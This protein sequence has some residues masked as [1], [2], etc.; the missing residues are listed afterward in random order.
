MIN[1]TYDN[2]SF[3][4]SSH[5]GLA[6]FHMALSH[7][8]IFSIAICMSPSFWAGLDS[9]IGSTLTK[10]FYSLEKSTLIQVTIF[11]SVYLMIP[12]ALI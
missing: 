5:G 7:P 2:R 3:L 8:K 12:T 4:G 9:L 1:I 6:A 11:L 10:I